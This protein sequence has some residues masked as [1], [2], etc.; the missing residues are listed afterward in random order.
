[1]YISCIVGMTGAVVLAAVSITQ[2]TIF[3]VLLGV[4]GFLDCLMQLRILKETQAEEAAD[5]YDLSAAWEN[6]DKPSPRRKKIKKRWLQSARKKAS[7][8]QAEQAR[9]DSILAKV[10]ER[11]LHSLTW[12]EKRTL[13]KATER[14]RRR[15][16][17]SRL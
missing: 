12:W 10:K 2:K 1:M 3:G 11:G 15:D 13:K 5:P 7:R 14:Q 9:I 4:F 17:A 8:D 6:P 16:L